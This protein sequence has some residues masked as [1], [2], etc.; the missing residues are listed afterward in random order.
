MGFEISKNCATMLQE[1]RRCAAM[2]FML[3]SADTVANRAR[4]R[5]NFRKH[6]QGRFDADFE[7]PHIVQKWK[8][9][10]EGKRAHTTIGRFGGIK[11]N[12]VNCTASRHTKQHSR[13]SKARGILQ[14]Q[15]QTFNAQEAKADSVN[16]WL[17]SAP[18]TDQTMEGCDEVQ[19]TLAGAKQ[20]EAGCNKDDDNTG[21]QIVDSEIISH[22][23]TGAA[24]KL[25]A[26]ASPGAAN[27]QDGDLGQTSSPARHVSARFE[28]HVSCDD[29]VQ[30]C[31]GK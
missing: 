30:H 8:S 16:A 27:M 12:W 13:E 11:D 25:C 26:G 28:C 17:D 14:G 9:D 4:T 31:L 20:C 10:Q 7:V 21:S 3:Q 29:L 6:V 18:A 15:E 23:T 1:R 2:R 5:H 24:P 22:S 19:L